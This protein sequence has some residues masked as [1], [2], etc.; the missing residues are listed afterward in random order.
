M[1]DLRA[2]K[3]TIDNADVLLV[4]ENPEKGSRNHLRAFH[5]NLLRQDA[6]YT[7]KCVTQA[8]N[9]ASVNSPK[10]GG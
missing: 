10:E 8:E 3:P 1:R 5:D 7:P 2:I 4:D 9:D 6:S